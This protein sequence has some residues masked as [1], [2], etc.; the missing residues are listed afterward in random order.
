M[1]RNLNAVVHL[2][3]VKEDS[4]TTLCHAGYT[5]TWTYKPLVNGKRRFYVL[6]AARYEDNPSF[7]ATREEYDRMIASLKA[8]REFYKK[9]TIGFVEEK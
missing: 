2:R 4:L 8:M 9:S 7:F 5:Y 6:P 3:L 1:N